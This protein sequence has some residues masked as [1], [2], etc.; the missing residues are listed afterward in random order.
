M[1]FGKSDVVA[2]YIST[3]F[4]SLSSHQ[5]MVI[6]REEYDHMA[7]SQDTNGDSH[8]SHH[9]SNYDSSNA[10]LAT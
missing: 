3:Y 5:T 4:V 8:A 10:L 7:H 1:K 2:N 6:S 9:A